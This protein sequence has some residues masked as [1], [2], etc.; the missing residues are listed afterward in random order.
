MKGSSYIQ[1]PSE[2]RDSVKGLINLQHKDNECFRWC[3]IRPLNPQEKVPQRIKRCDKALVEKLNYSEIEFPVAVKQYNKIE[4][5]NNININGFGYEDKQPYPIY[6]SKEKFKNIMNLLLITEGDSK[7][8]FFSKTLIC[9]CTT[10]LSINIES[11]SV[12]IVYKALVVM[13]C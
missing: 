11:I 2:L 9:P 7:H 6:V 8:M 1:L 10:K 4:K 12:C 5:L 3:H 13:M